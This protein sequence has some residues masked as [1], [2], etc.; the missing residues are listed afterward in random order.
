MFSIGKSISQNKDINFIFSCKNH[1][2]SI[3]FYPDGHYPYTEVL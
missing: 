2:F 3:A 1:Y